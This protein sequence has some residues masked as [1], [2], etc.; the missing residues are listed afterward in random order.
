M[1]TIQYLNT[2]KKEIFNLGDKLFKNPELGYKE[3]KTK[4]ILTDYL[5]AN[6]F[7]IENECF[8]TAFT[9]SIGSGHPHIGLIAEL[10]AI[11]T[12]GHPYANKKDN[13]A[14]HS[15]GH[16]TQ[17]TIMASVI[18]A[19][20]QKGIKNGKVTLFFTPAEEFTDVNY[21]KKLI[22]EKKIKY[23]GGKIN[24]LEK[25]MFDDVDILIHAHTMGQNPQYHFSLNTHLGGFVHKTITFKG[26]AAH[27][28]VLPYLGINALNAFTIFN[29]SVNALRETF[30]EEDM[31]R[32]HGIIT[33]GGQTVNA[34]PERVIYE[35]YVRSLNLNAIDEVSKKVDNAAIYSAKAIGANASIKTVPGYLPLVQE[36]RV[37]DIIKKEMLKYCKLEEINDDEISMAAGDIGDIS[38]FKPTVQFGYTGFKGVCHGKDLCVSDNNRAY[39]EPAKI[40]VKTVE[41]L[42]SNTKLTQKIIKEYKPRMSKK[43]YLAYINQK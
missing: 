33:E 18:S 7:K 11:P 9:V 10:D 15:C 3:F 29:T 24:M 31:I 19:L 20:K 5:K 43:D 12:L 16:S 39:L 27:A 37:N 2:H 30:K 1:E 42:L 26:K 22:K 28:A 8:E 32:I 40:I 6:G 17:C 35:C 23:I 21:R 13:N 36:R 34:I 25:G 41:E 14:A 38:V 4:E